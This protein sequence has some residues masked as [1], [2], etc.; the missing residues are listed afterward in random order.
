MGGIRLTRFVS[1]C[2][3]KCH[4]RYQKGGVFAPPSEV[5]SKIS[6]RGVRPPQ[7]F[8]EARIPD[9]WVDSTLIN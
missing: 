1:I 9:L 7:M 8:K 2:S 5:G 3:V 4:T 6:S